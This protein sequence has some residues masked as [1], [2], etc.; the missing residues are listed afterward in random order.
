MNSGQ[1]SE[2]AAGRGNGRGRGGPSERST[3]WDQSVR[4]ATG[5]KPV[6]EADVRD[7]VERAVE[8]TVSKKLDDATARI[9]RNS[10]SQLQEVMGKIAQLLPSNQAGA[11][12]PAANAER[13]APAEDATPPP[14]FDLRRVETQDEKIVRL[15]RELQVARAQGKR[16]V[17][18]GANEL[19]PGGSGAAARGDKPSNERRGPGGSGL[20]ASNRSP[21]S[22]ADA[23]GKPH[24]EERFPI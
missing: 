9:E 3:R 2:A 23:D 10:A 17:E 16:P 20:Q 4:S 13:A 22:A 6:T 14:A 21:A 1:Y 7:M 15:E 24:L 8:N 11:A 5:A 12:L 19:A 18:M